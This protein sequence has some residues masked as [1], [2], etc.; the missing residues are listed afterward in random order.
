MIKTK[1]AEVSRRLTSMHL[2]R[3]LRLLLLIEKTLELFGHFGE[4]RHDVNPIRLSNRD[5]RFNVLGEVD[6][7]D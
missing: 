6:K 1:D 7:S 3:G 2:G 4:E 5:K